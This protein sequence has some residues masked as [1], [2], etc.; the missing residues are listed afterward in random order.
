MRVC[1]RVRLRVEWHIAAVAV[2][3]SDAWLGVAQLGCD[4]QRILK[5]NSHN[6]YKLNKCPTLAHAPHTHT[7]TTRHIAY[8]FFFAV[9]SMHVGII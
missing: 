1:E 7:P 4:T 9:C 5:E 8:I 6:K 2:D 3:A